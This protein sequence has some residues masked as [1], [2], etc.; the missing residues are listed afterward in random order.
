MAQG[1]RI[2]CWTALSGAQWVAES[3][4]ALVSLRNEQGNDL[5]RFRQWET[6][7]FW[8][9]MGRQEVSGRILKK[10]ESMQEWKG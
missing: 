1:L 10:Q 7:I 8:N 9:E 2:R 4:K 6:G 3:V 5:E